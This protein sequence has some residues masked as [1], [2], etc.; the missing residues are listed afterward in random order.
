MD[1]QSI[2]NQKD[3]HIIDVREVPEFNTGHVDIAINMPLSTI[4]D[5]IDQIKTMEGPK[6]LYCRSGNRSGQAV[7]FL[8]DLGV[9]DI[10]NG[11][12]FTLMSSYMIPNYSN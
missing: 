5:F 1:I 11:G 8:S 6:V 3:A 12:S 4:R 2:V 10:Y 7:K 9:S